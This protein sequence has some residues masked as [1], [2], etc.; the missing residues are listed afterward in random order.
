MGIIAAGCITSVH[1]L[2]TDNEL[3]FRPELIGTWRDGNDILTFKD[4]D[5]THYAIQNI[6]DSDTTQ[7]IGRLGK[8]GNHY[9]LDITID[10]DDKK[11]D[12]LL[13]MY[14]FPVHMFFKV[15]FENDQ[16]SMNAFAFSSDWLEKLIKERRIRIDHEVEN[17]QILLTTSTDELQEFVLKYA[18]EPKAFDDNPSVYNRTITK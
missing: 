17:K 12:D 18:N 13:G 15:S 6:E 2:F 1:P 3:I 16:L 11:V 8:L 10:P 9:F 4:I 5:S 7:L 14:V